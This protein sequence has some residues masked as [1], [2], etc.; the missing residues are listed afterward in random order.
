MTPTMKPL[1]NPWMDLFENLVMFSHFCH[2]EE[3]SFMTPTMKP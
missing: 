3:Y 1:K 2:K